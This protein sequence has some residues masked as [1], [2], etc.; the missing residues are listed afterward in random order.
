MES[1]G[2]R[3]FQTDETECVGSFTCFVILGVIES[4]LER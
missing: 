4:Y 3:A 2:R 1:A